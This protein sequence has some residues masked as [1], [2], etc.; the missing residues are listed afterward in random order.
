M[1]RTAPCLC[2][3]GRN[4]SPLSRGR[5]RSNTAH[6]LPAINGKTS[7]WA[8]LREKLRTLQKSYEPTARSKP[9]R[10]APCSRTPPEASGSSHLGMWPA[11]AQM[12]GGVCRTRPTPPR[13]QQVQASSRPRSLMQWATAVVETSCHCWSFSILGGKTKGPRSRQDIVML[14]SSFTKTD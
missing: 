2:F 12:N 3:P 13:T 14:R 4:Q 6:P 9:G 10:P 7:I 11:H 5:R 8:L 1:H